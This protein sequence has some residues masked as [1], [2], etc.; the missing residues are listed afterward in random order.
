MT[1]LCWNFIATIN[2][3]SKPNTLAK[4][5]RIRGVGEL[6]VG[7][8]RRINQLHQLRT[9][10]FWTQLMKAFVAETYCNQ[11]LIDSVTYLLTIN[12]STRA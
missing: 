4:T 5:V 6:I 11:L 12:S 10:E 1:L 7:K 3:Y 9:K 2:S 8:C